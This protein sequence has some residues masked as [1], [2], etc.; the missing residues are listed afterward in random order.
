MPLTT[1][2]PPGLMVSSSWLLRLRANCG[3]PNGR[4]G[5]SMPRAGSF[6]LLNMPNPISCCRGGDAGGEDVCD[7][8]L[9]SSCLALRTPSSLW[10]TSFC[11]STFCSRFPRS[12]STLSSSFCR[13]SVSASSI[14]RCSFSR[15]ASSSSWR[16]FSILSS[17]ACFAR[18][19]ARASAS[20]LS[21]SCR[22][23]SFSF[24]S[25]SLA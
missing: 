9:R 13:R 1:P 4:A 24:C 22:C 15:A 2:P 17:S 14:S 23:R 20:Y 16:S 6:L 25:M 12:C 18:F 21:L 7:L 19:L 5:A 10:R 3:G 11:G 8:K